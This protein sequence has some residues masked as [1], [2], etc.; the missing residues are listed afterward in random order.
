VKGY[1]GIAIA[2]PVLPH[3]LDSATGVV[4]GSGYQYAYVDVDGFVIGVTSASI[5]AMPNGIVVIDRPRLKGFRSGSAVEVRRD[6]I[7]SPDAGISLR[8]ASV[9]DPA[10]SQEPDADVDLLAIGLEIWRR[11]RLSRTLDP[12]EIVDRLDRAGFE[13][14]SD[15]DGRAGLEALFGSLADRDPELARR[16]AELLIGRGPGLTPEGDDFLAATA[17]TMFACEASIDW[18]DRELVAW[19]SFVLPDELRHKTTALS[20]TLLELA[21]DGCVSEP[22]QTL[23]DLE[24]SSDDWLEALGRLKKVGHGTGRA[25]AAGCAATAILLTSAQ[26]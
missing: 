22:V 21:V 3:L 2:A 18:T 24:A 9:W 11:L 1:I 14:A 25:W 5:P 13:S 16:A 23:F 17:A 7:L 10:V 15:P 12:V 6:A 26:T 8:R 20:A 4:R 19:R